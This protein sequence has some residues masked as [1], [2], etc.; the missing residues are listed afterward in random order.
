M[1]G[2]TVEN[3]CTPGEAAKFAAKAAE[4][5]ER[6]QI[7]EAELRVS[8]GESAEIEV[9]QNFLRTGNKAFNPGMTAMVNGLA[10]GACCK[11]ILLPAGYVGHGTSCDNATYGIVGSQMD[12]DYVCYMAIN[13]VPALKVMARMEGIEHGH[14]KGKLMKWCNQYLMGAA[15]E[16]CKRLE[17]ERQAR[18]E[19]KAEE[20]RTGNTTC[21]ALITGTSLAVAKREATDTAFDELYPNTR[22]TFTRCGYDPVA[23][24]A[25][26]E[27]GKRVGLNLPL[28]GSSA[29]NRNLT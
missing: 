11:V 2:N 24:Q 25:G 16:I 28:G 18:S 3:G 21:T 17:A 22:K 29:A 15:S 5:I 26:R 14:E 19:V 20:H 1:L 4:W 7:E 23:Q 8:R 10:Q 12:A 27:A 9:C 6:H 13:L